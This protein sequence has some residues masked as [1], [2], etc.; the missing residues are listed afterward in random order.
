VLDSLPPLENRDAIKLDPDLRKKKGRYHSVE[1]IFLSI[2]GDVFIRPARRTVTEVAEAYVKIKRTGGQPLGWSAERT[3][4]MVEPQNTLASRNHSAVIFVGPSQAGKTESLVMNFIA[5]SAIQDPMD[6]IL[7]NPSTQAA[8]DFSIRR[9][10]RMNYNSPELMRRLVRSRE[11]DT[12][13]TKI[14]SSGMILNLSWPTVTE[15]AGK[16]VGRVVL[17]DYDRMPDDIGGEGSP[18]DLAYM[19]TTT[20][21]SLRMC[22][23][24]SSP[25]RPIEDPR[26]HAATPHEAP[27][28]KG[29]VG[30]YNRGDRRRWY[31]PCA[32]C[33][34]YFEGKFEHLQWDNTGS[35][36]ESAE[37]VR[38]ICPVCNGTILPADRV[39]MQEYALWL[40][41]GQS[42]DS[43]GRIVG[44][45]RHTDI[46]SYWLTGV[47]AGF[48]TWPEMVTKFLNAEAEYESA[49]S[50]QSLQQFFNNVIGVPYKSKVETLLRLPEALHTRAEPLGEYVVPSFVRLL[51]ATV[52]VQKNLFVVQVHGI[53]PGRPYDI[54]VIDRYQ[55]RKS[56]RLD[57]EGEREWVKPAS[58]LEDWDLLID[59][60]MMRS[61]A[62]SDGSGRE[63]QIKLTLCDSG[64]FNLHRGEGV[65]TQ[66]YDFW[67][68][69][70]KRGFA[71]R[72]HLVKGDG[73][74]AAP[75]TWIDYPD[76]RNKSKLATARGDVP[77]LFLNSN[78]LKDSL[79]ARL[80]SVEPGTGM[81]HFA[82][83]LPA[84][85]YKELCAENRTE[86]GWVNTQGTRNEAW[87]LLY[88][89]I[90]GCASP[91]LQV[92][93]IDWDQPPSWAA[94]W[95]K[96]PLVF[97]P[98]D[99]DALLDGEPVLYNFS[100]LGKALA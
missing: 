86:K 99:K 44:K 96:N 62:L 32:R 34:E 94:S 84:W 64:G 79:S 12:K 31:W 82:D 11:A 52:D 45:S 25:S 88:Y 61:Y 76:Q 90:G 41:D 8:R 37:T 46:A 85:F 47:A 49:Q 74:P 89:A 10:D 56:R 2:V 26:W 28:C 33:G 38:M 36:M 13:L 40:A 21:G 14:Y 65:T 80:D 87:D 1:Q 48:Q 78:V 68:S 92:E 35:P 43:E 19:R 24:E 16:P 29:I 63:M 7:Y 30:L 83:W 98:E 66:A 3:P 60:V 67:R 77:V 5:Y 97:N 57:H 51:V 55:I 93:K 20:Y 53:G 75:R 100:D 69:L 15:M 18:F 73:R 17:T 50:E 71:G 59:E 23:A 6:T 42:L 22:V 9:I 58:Y 70:R 91:L 95:D 39:A 27:P 54:A 81:I 72:F 4:Y